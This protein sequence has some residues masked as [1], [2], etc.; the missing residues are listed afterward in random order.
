[1]SCDPQSEL[2]N[3]VLPSGGQKRKHKQNGSDDDLMFI[4][5]RVSS[6][7]Y[8][9]HLP[10]PQAPDGPAPLCR[11][12]IDRTDAGWAHCLG[13]QG[14]PPSNPFSA[15]ETADGRKLQKDPSGEISRNPLISDDEGHF[16]YF[17]GVL[18]RVQN[19]ARVY[20][21]R[22][23]RRRRSFRSRGGK[24]TTPGES[25]KLHPGAY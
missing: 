16:Y 1:M 7:D 15:W 3:N 25:P 13:R 4:N 6:R 8:S 5:Q 11:G 23:R 14:G 22:Q 24:R 10:S 21:R 12:L 2:Y 20:R 9:H 19:N 17:D 18:K